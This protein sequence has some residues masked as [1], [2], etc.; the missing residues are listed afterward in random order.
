MPSAIGETR[1][2]SRRAVL[3]SHLATL[4]LIAAAFSSL[5]LVDRFQLTYISIFYT[6]FEQIEPI[7]LAITAL[8]AV[9]ALALVWWTRSA[10]TE[11]TP[12]EFRVP[13]VKLATI[14]LSAAV[15]VL[16]SLGVFF[17]FHHFF[18]ADDEYSAWFQANIF[19]HGQR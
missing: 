13:A 5:P 16:V 10:E 7:H 2:E 4:A 17:V 15:L 6:Q 18:L 1:A 3:I 19:A 8:F 12:A 9:A 14:G 11:A